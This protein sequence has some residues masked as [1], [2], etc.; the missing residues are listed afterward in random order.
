MFTEY[1]KRWSS[2]LWNSLQSPVTSSSLGTKKVLAIAQAFHSHVPGSSSDQLIWDLWWTSRTGSG[3][4][5]V[6]R[7]PL[8]ILIPPTASRSSSHLFRGCYNGPNSGPRT[9]P[10]HPTPPHETM[11]TCSRLVR[12]YRASDELHMRGLAGSVGTR[13]R[14]VHAVAA[15]LDFTSDLD[16]AFL[17]YP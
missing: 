14:S 16:C 5:R 8:P 10:P 12:H 15:Q 2:S 17:R 7:F 9:T 6:Y 13:E 4:V 11:G 3:F 1:Y